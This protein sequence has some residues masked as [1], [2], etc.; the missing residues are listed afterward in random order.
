MLETFISPRGHNH[1]K[2]VNSA[3]VVWCLNLVKEPARGLEGTRK[4]R[5]S[6]DVAEAVSSLVGVV[7]WSGKLEPGSCGIADPLPHNFGGE[8]AKEDAFNFFV[9]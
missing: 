4:V 8:G 9:L 5:G 1:R 3:P 7:E 6:L 2:M